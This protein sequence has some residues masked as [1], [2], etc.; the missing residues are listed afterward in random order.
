MGLS[1]AQEDFHVRNLYTT[2]AR[3]Q[4]MDQRRKAPLVF[5]TCSS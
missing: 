2:P 5:A 4:R 1:K 3:A